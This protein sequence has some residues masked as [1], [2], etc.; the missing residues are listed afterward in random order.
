MPS[1]L[2]VCSYTWYVSNCVLG[3]FFEFSDYKKFI[4]RTQEYKDIPSPIVPSLKSLATALGCTGFFILLQNY[5]WCEYIY[6][7]EYASHSFAYK[8]VYYYTAMTVKRFFYYGPFMFVTGAFRA[9]G[10]GYEG[11]GKW[12]KVRG[13]YI[14]EIETADSVN[15]MLRA[16]NH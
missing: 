1:P 8:V 6:S 13:V 7:P 10:L 15:T 2:E 12:D 5:F 4:E 11:N 16:W 3:V 9:T 14:Y